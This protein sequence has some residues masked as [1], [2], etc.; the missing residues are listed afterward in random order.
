LD[1]DLDG[2]RHSLLRG[3][4]PPGPLGPEDGEL[5]F[6]RH[7]LL[8]IRFHR[9]AGLNQR[10]RVGEEGKGW[11]QYFNEY[12]PKR[13][14][15]KQGDEQLLWTDW[16]CGLVKWE[17]PKSKV[18]VTHGQPDWHWHREPSGTLCINLESM[19]LDFETSVERFLAALRDDDERRGEAVRRWRERSWTIR[20]LEVASHPSGLTIA[21][22]TTQSASA[23]A[24][25]N[26]T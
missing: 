3:L 10:A 23:I 24:P 22:S 6:E 16:R 26:R 4:R 11:R 5:A 15:W 12:F 8:A 17:T 7:I 18:A 20:P 1:T 19:W 14:G 25:S 9:A 21:T 13:R 2:I